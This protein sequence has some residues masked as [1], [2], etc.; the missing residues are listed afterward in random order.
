MRPFLRAT[1]VVLASILGG[2][3]TVRAQ[4]TDELRRPQPCAPCPP[5]ARCIVAPCPP[6]TK[7]PGAER[8]SSH[9]RASMDGRIVR[10][11]IDD[12]YVNRGGRVA[13]VDYVLPLPKG[14]AFENIELSINGE[15]IAGETMRA[16]RA[17]AVY[18]EIV[19]KLRDPALVE[20]MG[21][22]LLRAR[23]F[24]IQPGEEKR[25]AVRFSAVAQREG[26]ALRLDWPARGAMAGRSDNDWFELRYSDTG[27]G[28]TLG[29]AYSP[30][31][32]LSVTDRTRGAR[33]VRANDVTRATTVLV[34]VR[35]CSCG[36]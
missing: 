1:A 6:Q 31:H 25:V 18:E 8:I 10:Y 30:T 7:F 36:W 20:W 33:T 4:V 21:H 13:E 3:A 22:D 23:I 17:R 2:A 35:R 29:T 16:E 12:R 34:P 24:P 26:D 32:N 9:V 27:A 5:R 15:M 11:E 19:R 14:A 28:E